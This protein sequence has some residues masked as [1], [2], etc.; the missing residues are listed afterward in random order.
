MTPKRIRTHNLRTMALEALLAAGEEMAVSQ[1]GGCF[2]REVLLLAD[3]E[4]VWGLGS[5]CPVSSEDR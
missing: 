3:M 4:A 1:E 5:E 2:G